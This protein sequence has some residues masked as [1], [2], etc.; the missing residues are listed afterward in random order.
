MS[1]K[2]FIIGCG[3]VGT[4][5]GKAFKDA[6]NRIIGIFDTEPAQARVAAGILGVEAFG[7]AL[8][9]VIKDADMILVAVPDSAIEQV[10]SLAQAEE[11]YAPQQVW[12]HC[13]GRLTSTALS[14]LAT[15]VKGVGS[16]HPAYVFPPKTLTEI[17][18]DV[19]FAVEG[20]ESAVA[21]IEA[22]VKELGGHV[23]MVPPAARTAYHAAMVM[24]SNYMVTLLAS[25][26][27][28]LKSIGVDED[29]IAPLLFTLSLSAISRAKLL[30]IGGSLCGPIRRGDM[31]AVEDHVHALSELPHEK[32]LYIAA[33]K[34][35]VKLAATQPGYCTDT[36]LTLSELLDRL[37]IE[38]WSKKPHP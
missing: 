37:A 28:I 22:R 16:M 13:S 18:S 9:D 17:P 6:G 21:M 36:A 30:G 15:F 3:A 32:A 38:H 26:R 12:V 25:A 8:P 7:G 27:E 19:F 11:L 4:S 23:V 33:G 2:V 24:A 1:D 29:L 14:P 34:A 31:G 20:D 5:L 35:A 10:A